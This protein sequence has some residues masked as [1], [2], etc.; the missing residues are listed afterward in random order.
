MS[1]PCHFPAT[2]SIIFCSQT[3]KTHGEFSVK[4]KWCH[5]I[6]L[7]TL[8][9]ILTPKCTLNCLKIH[10]FTIQCANWMCYLHLE[11]LGILLQLLIRNNS[12]VP[13]AHRFMFNT[14][15]YV[16]LYVIFI[17]AAP[18]DISNFNFLVLMIEFVQVYCP[19]YQLCSLIFTDN[20]ASHKMP[21]KLRLPVP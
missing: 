16:A 7:P 8:S 10:T 12:F 21:W 13:S 5:N 20:N 6:L 15:Y 17:S 3:R 14:P 4:K 2:S 9:A 11:L 1:K 18:Q 19:H